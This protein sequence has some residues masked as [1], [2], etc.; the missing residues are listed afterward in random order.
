MTHLHPKHDKKV[1][2]KNDP[3]IIGLVLQRKKKPRLVSSLL[4]KYVTSNTK[5]DKEEMDLI[6][7]TLKIPE[8]YLES[9]E[10]KRQIL[11]GFMDTFQLIGSI[12]EAVVHSNILFKQ[13]VDDVNVNTI[14]DLS[15]SI[16][17]RTT[18]EDGLLTI[19]K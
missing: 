15:R 9:K 17:Y 12:A 6:E 10:A 3:Y 18:Y 19:Y 1:I 2:L 14:V 5:L 16:G 13:Y 7:E 8:Y 4:E 11:Q